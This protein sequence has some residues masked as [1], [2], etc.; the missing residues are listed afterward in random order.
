MKTV[1]EIRRM[2][3]A[4]L[5]ERYGTLTELNEKL[6]LLRR[7]STL[8]Q[9]LN[10]SRSSTGK[11]KEMGSALA[12]RLEL[13]LGLEVGWM[14]ND[15]A[16]DSPQQRLSQEAIDLAREFDRAEAH[17]REAMLTLWHQLME[18]SHHGQ[19]ARPAAASQQR[20]PSGGRT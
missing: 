18:I 16:Y 3:L 11:S 8:S 20:P 14:D 7:D 15:P 6:G 4:Q 17:E 5:R 12:R 9:V 13:A 1:E 10:S 2:R 19:G